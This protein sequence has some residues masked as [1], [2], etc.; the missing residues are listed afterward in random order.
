MERKA[1]K[2]TYPCNLLELRKELKLTQKQLGEILGTSERMICNYET[3][4]ITLPIDKAILLC[5]KY[6]YTLDWIYCY[7]AK[8]KNTTAFLGKMKEYPQFVVDIRD[9]LSYSDDSVFFT[10]PNY[11]WEY[12]KKRNAIAS[13]KS[14][15]GDKKRK[16]AELNGAYEI[17]ENEQKY[18][19]ISITA[20]NFLPYLRFASKYIPFADDSSS[21]LKEPSKEQIE[22]AAEFLKSLTDANDEL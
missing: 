9:F 10:I 2:Q 15:D 5:Q 16:I 8:P 4:E 22:E 19:R 13:S 6:N 21:S 17:Q 3:G 18:W 20:K 12:I 1:N 11:Y 7:P 14:T